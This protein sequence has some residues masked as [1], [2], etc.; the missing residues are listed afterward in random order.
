ML[1]DLDSGLRRNGV[2]A[3]LVPAQQRATT[4]VAPYKEYVTVFR[5]CCTKP[6]PNLSKHLPRVES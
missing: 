2:G 3:G 1:E 4:R 5:K 6:E